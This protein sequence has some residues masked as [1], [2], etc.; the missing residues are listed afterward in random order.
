MRNQTTATQFAR[1]LGKN[2]DV[3]H[4]F[5]ALETNRK[6]ALFD[7]LMVGNNDNSSSF[8]RTVE[9]L[10]PHSTRGDV[11]KLESFL[12]RRLNTEG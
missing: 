9:F 11:L 5:Q 12:R 1:D 6:M 7:L 4:A 10:W 8:K 3:L 2:F